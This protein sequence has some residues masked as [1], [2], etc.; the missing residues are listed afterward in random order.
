MVILDVPLIS[1]NHS[2]FQKT[3]DFSDF[4]L[5]FFCFLSDLI[6]D[7]FVIFFCFFSAPIFHLATCLAKAPVPKNMTSLQH[8]HHQNLWA[9]WP[10]FLSSLLQIIDQN[11]IVGL[12]QGRFDL[13]WL[14]LHLLL[15]QSL[16]S[17]W[18]RNFFYQ[19]FP[20]EEIPPNRFCGYRSSIK[21]KAMELVLAERKQIESIDILAVGLKHCSFKTTEGT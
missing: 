2:F 6:S 21:I 14:G 12:H 13:H 16:C 19:V 5:I 1:R 18:S 15:Q 7:V 9:T 11:R 10:S 17:Q 4:F 20:L 8:A 3:R